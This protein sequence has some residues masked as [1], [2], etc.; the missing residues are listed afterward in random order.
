MCGKHVVRDT[1]VM[2]DGTFG[3]YIQD[4]VMCSIGLGNIANASPLIVL[5][6]ESDFGDQ[7]GHLIALLRNLAEGTAAI[8][9]DH[10]LR[11]LADQI[12]AQT[13]PARIPEP[14]L[15][16]V[17]EASVDAFPA[18]IWVRRGPGSFC[19]W[20]SPEHGYAVW[21][22]LIDPTLVREGMTK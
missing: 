18:T 1:V 11:N 17:V 7:H 20:H 21:D 2:V 13:K 14:G 16:G 19:R 8:Y 5:D 6:L 4:G 3:Y 22:I 15:W 9:T 12:E 10:L